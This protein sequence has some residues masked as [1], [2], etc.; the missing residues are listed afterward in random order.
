MSVAGWWR[1]ATTP[2][3]AAWSAAAHGLPGRTDAD[4]WS[5]PRRSPPWYPDA[6]TLRPDVDAGHPA[7]PGRRRSRGVGEGQ[8]RR[9]GP[10][11]VRL[12]GALRRPV[13]PPAGEADPAGRRAADPGDHPAGTGRLGGGARWR[14]AVPAGP[15]GRPAG[16]RCW[17]GTTT[18]GRSPA[19][20]WCSGDDVCGVS[21]VFART[22][23]PQDIWHGVCATTPGVPLVG[24]ES[25]PDLDAA[26]A[27][28]F[29]PVGPLRVW[30]HG[31]GRGWGGGP[32]SLGGPGLRGLAGA[33]RRRCSRPGAPGRRCRGWPARA[34]P[35]AA[36]RPGVPGAG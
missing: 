26:Q 13:D 20:R 29:T 2:R 17:P 4:A 1:L 22:V 35:G 28:G 11:P 6:V 8:L 24:Y 16:A 34:G 7:G 15:A 9:P 18:V 27:A 30:L 31:A 3:G 21:N 25:G 10:D 19:G 12:P 32:V 14:G 23:D 33:R 36:S 5:V